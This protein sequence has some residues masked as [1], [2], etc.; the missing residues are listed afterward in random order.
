[1]ASENTS[2]QK[3]WN[4]TSIYILSDLKMYIYARTQTNF[5][6]EKQIHAS[7][8]VLCT[9]VYTKE[10]FEKLERVD[11]V[12][13]VSGKEN[14]LPLVDTNIVLFIDDNNIIS[15]EKTR[16][17]ETLSFYPKMFKGKR[18]FFSSTAMRSKTPP[19]MDA[20]SLSTIWQ[21]L[22]LSEIPQA[23]PKNNEIKKE[24]SIKTDDSSK[25]TNKKRTATKDT[26]NKQTVNESKVKDKGNELINTPEEEL[27]IANDFANVG[28][29]GSNEI[30]LKKELV[31]KLFECLNTSGIFKNS[32]P[33]PPTGI[34]D[35][36]S[37]DITVLNDVM[38]K[39]FENTDDE[40][41]SMFSCKDNVKLAIA[42]ASAFIFNSNGSIKRGLYTGTCFEYSEIKF[43]VTPGAF[44]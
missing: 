42:R 2:N 37:N 27:E 6:T 33:Q 9:S 26:I 43:A 35:L 24:V 1:M 19:G 18:S 21:S 30:S 20:D 15:A 36:D 13:V 38:V 34:E 31:S 39:F 3:N 16:K 5:I 29:D 10:Q 32:T 25:S 23:M 40:I 17:H 22:G 4:K 41:K 44:F 14:Y 28:N 11:R 7:E 8:Q 12:I